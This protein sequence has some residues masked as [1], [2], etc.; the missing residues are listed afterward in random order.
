M[1]AGENNNFYPI[2]G[3]VVPYGAIEPRTQMP[4]WQEQIDGYVEGNRKIFAGPVPKRLSNGEY[5]TAYFLGSHAA[6]AV[7]IQAEDPEPF[8]AV[9][10]LRIA[11][12]SKYILAGEIVLNLFPPEDADCDNY[13]QDPAFGGKLHTKTPAHLLFADGHVGKFRG[14]DPALMMT[15][16][17][18]QV[19]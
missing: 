6:Y 10:R 19:P 9:H 12:P 15:T 3:T 1:Y 7:A 8:Q 13:S 4:S 16:Y 18:D 5:R 11:S 17:S 14:Y 2:A